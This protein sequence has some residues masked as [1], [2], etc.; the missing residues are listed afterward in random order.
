MVSTGRKRGRGNGDVRDTDCDDGRD[1]GRDKLRPEHETRLDLEIVTELE[2]L[3]EADGLNRYFD[4]VHPRQSKAIDEDE[5]NSPVRLEE[6][7]RERLAWNRVSSD[8]LA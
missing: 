6:H 1:D 3:G 2:I 8:Q 4:T 5:G 7:V